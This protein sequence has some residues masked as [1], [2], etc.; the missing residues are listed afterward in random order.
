MKRINTLENYNQVPKVT[1]NLISLFS[2][3][4]LTWWLNINNAGHPILYT[5]LV[6]GEIFHVFQVLGY[7]FTVYDV[8]RPK[9]EKVVRIHPV[10]IFVTVCGEPVEIV[11]KTLSAIKKLN[12]PNFKVYVLNDGYVAKKDNWQEIDALAIKY[13]ATPITRTTPGGYKAGNI[14]NALRF[15]D[16]PFIAIFDADHIPDTSFLARTMGYFKNDNLA[17]VQTP[18]YYENHKDNFVTKNSW[19]QQELFFGPICVG[20]NSSNSAFW[21]G[22]N[23]VVRRQALE[24]VGGVP[25][26]NIAEDFL[27]SMFLHSKGWETLYIPEILS[28]GMAPMNLRDYVVQQF[29]WARGS[30]EMIFI[31]NP[32]FRKG[33]TWKQKFQYIWSSSY[34]LSGL[35]VLIDAV[36]PLLALGFDVLPV[37]AETTDF[38]VYFFP[39]ISSTIYLLVSSTNH[40]LTF[41]AIQMSNSSF[42]IFILAMLSTIFRFKVSFK[43]TP[44]TQETGNYLLYALPHILYVIAGVLAISV[45]VSRHGITPAI[46]NNISWALFNI[47]FFS[48]FIKAAYPWEKLYPKLFKPSYAIRETAGRISSVMPDLSLEYASNPNKS[49]NQKV[50]NDQK[51]EAK[52]D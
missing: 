11:E 40:Q 46:A 35:I 9:F 39:F 15:T 4:Y 23:A 12:Y 30:L 42:Y 18:Q 24:Q 50:E 19:E 38:L 7:A 31:Y 32:I 34:Y 25:E 1:I 29:R 14:N 26:N 45:G 51:R 5:L 10:D 48:A 17:L 43:V 49:E 21:C 28:K 44:K 27:A 37:R 20:K 33:L 47:V 41:N 6:L 52:Y 22:T 36:I 16:A 13:G 3:F 8:K 2:L